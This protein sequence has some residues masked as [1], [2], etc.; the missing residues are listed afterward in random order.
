MG[1]SPKRVTILGSGTSTGIPVIGCD[2]EVC[3][4]HDPRN[5][6]TRA[7]IYVA[8][9]DGVQM[10]VDTGPEFRLQ[11]IREGIT[12]LN[13]VLYTHLH[14]DHCHGFDDLRALYFRS[15]EPV[16]CYLC[17]D[18]EKEL[19]QRFSYAF[20]DTGYLGTKPQVVLKQIPDDGNFLV[21]NK[22]IETFRIA[23]GNVQT[24]VFRFGS[25]AYATDFKEFNAD[26]IVRWKGKI[27]VMVASGI[28][29]GTHNTHSVIEETLRLFEAL[30]VERGVI[31]HISHKIEHLRDSAKLPAGVEL[32][33]D[34]M[35]IDLA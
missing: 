21:A 6:R 17:S 29:F 24:S 11:M 25:F 32:A 10:V 18:F 9:D 8:Y 15:K 31:T 34:G 13:G 23:H 35:V 16:N 1:P 19:R 33:Y 3:S 12:D 20:I 4:S 27:K 7:S 28:H 22:P 5:T 30:N 2:C 14:A 26:Q